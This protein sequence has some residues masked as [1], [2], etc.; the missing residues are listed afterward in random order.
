MG[1]NQQEN[2]TKESPETEVEKLKASDVYELEQPLP[3]RFE[4]PA[5]RQGYGNYMKKS[6]NRVYIALQILIMVIVDQLHLTCLHVMNRE[7][8]N[9]LI[10]WE[11][12][13]RNSG[14]VED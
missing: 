9:F 5:C 4:E 14:G 11:N 12:V 1:K 6:I 3:K 10:I 7:H 2:E 13:G 8:K